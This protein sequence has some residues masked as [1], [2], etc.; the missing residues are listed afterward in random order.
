MGEYMVH[1]VNFFD[2]KPKSIQSAFA[3]EI[4]KK[5]AVSRYFLIFSIELSS[6]ACSKLMFTSIQS[7]SKQSNCSVI[8]LLL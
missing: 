6:R 5:L 8:F 4:N 1:R 3:D 2:F 7:N